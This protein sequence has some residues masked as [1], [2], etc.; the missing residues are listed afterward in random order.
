MEQTT[1]SRKILLRILYGFLFVIMVISIIGIW[2]LKPLLSSRIKEAVSAS[3]NELYQI[4][5]KDIQYSPMTGNAEIKSV[6]W[7]AD[8]MLFDKLRSEEKLPNSVFKCKVEE[9]KLTGL[10]PW[11]II[12]SKKL[13]INTI[14][15]T[16][17]FIE[18]LHEKHAYNASNKAK[19]PY[20]VISKFVKSFSV[21]KINLKNIS[22]T[23]TNLSKSKRTKSSKIESLDLE[24]SNFLIDSL[25]HKDTARFYY[26]KECKI[27][28][29]KFEFPSADSLNTFSLNSLAFSSK[30]RSLVIQEL[31]LKPHYKPI[32]YG[33]KSNGND[34]IEVLC[35]SIKL[36]DIDVEKLFEEKKI[37]A[38][39]LSIDKG[40]LDIFSEDRPFLRPTKANYRL[41]PHQ[42]F[43]RLNLKCNI[44]LIKL[45]RIDVKFSQY[46]PETRL[47]GS[48]YFNTIKGRITNVTND[49][50]PLQQNP[51]CEAYLWMR[52]MKKNPVNLAFNF[53]LKDPNGAFGCKG[54]VSAMPFSE[55]N[56]ATYAL[57]KAKV[58]SGILD[59]FSFN[60]QGN[61]FSLTGPVTLLYHDLKVNL[62]KEQKETKLMKRMKFLSFLANNSVLKSSNPLKRKPATIAQVNYKRDPQ[63]GFF[64]VF[65]R[66]L[67]DGIKETVI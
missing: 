48:L 59:R 67:L 57:A 5:F 18:I 16:N 64:T 37:Y 45:Q 60:L 56:Q 26:T 39:E 40:K 14:S 10:K 38:K 6:T 4:D 29:K 21:D 27:N 23:Y 24:V 11:T 41:Y 61:K 54:E 43:S 3:T 63:K 35:Q 51:I 15:V 32:L 13:S 50:I 44:Q 65:W 8:S 19:T 58:V 17:P 52:F 53:N 46:N 55:L 7:L 42:A 2:G 1:D 28:L 20:E 22:L 47:T 12:F 36:S 62:W 25:S 49:T 66:A 9:I 30:N 34:R 31:A 33:N